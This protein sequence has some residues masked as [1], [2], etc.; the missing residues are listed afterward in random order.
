M[1]A[2]TTLP[3]ELQI[4]IC[5]YFFDCNFTDPKINIV[6]GSYGFI[7]K[8]MPDVLN[9]R[10]LARA[11][12][13]FLQACKESVT[14]RIRFAYHLRCATELQILKEYQTPASSH[15]TEKTIAAPVFS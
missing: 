14:P 13:V 7:N 2:F 15:G 8:P 4:H 12:K 3:N 1:A 9:A 5:K 10:K 6:H 11:S